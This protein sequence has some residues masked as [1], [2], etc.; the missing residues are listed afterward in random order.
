MR[1]TIVIGDIHGCYDELISLLEKID[2]RSEDRVVAVGD[3]VVKGSRNKEVLDLFSG[4]ARFSSVI[5]NHDLA[6][7]RFW[8]GEAISLKNS[9]KKTCIELQT[10]K[11][12]YL[13]YLNSLPFQ[14]DL[15]SHLIVHAGIRPGVPLSEQA[16]EDLTELRTLGADRTSRTGL[17]W[18]DVYNEEKVVLFGHWPAPEPRRGRHAI[19][20]DTGCV[21]GYRLTSYIL[22]TDEFVSVKANRAY[23]V[24]KVPLTIATR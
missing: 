14:I 24:P 8:R 5:G 9:Q 22:E 21:Y 4:D 6:L 7:V 13:G 17:P 10:N 2:L 15:G 18:Y 3:L 11:S 16:E 1:R 19:G 23:D 20:L 12:L